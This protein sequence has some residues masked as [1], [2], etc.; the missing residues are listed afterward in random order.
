MSWISFSGNV[1]PFSS[2]FKQHP[3]LRKEQFQMFFHYFLHFRDLVD[4]YERY[5]SWVVLK[6]LRD[7]QKTLE[8]FI[9]DTL[10]CLDADIYDGLMELQDYVI[11]YLS[12]KEWV[13]MEE[14]EFE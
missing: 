2:S 9:Q 1:L 13:H 14:E 3:F 5:Q 11:N 10:F 6:S 4:Q 12:H 7:F 8:D